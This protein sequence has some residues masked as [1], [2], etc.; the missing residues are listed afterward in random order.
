VIETLEAR[1]RESGC[2]IRLGE[3]VVSLSVHEKGGK[4]VY[5]IALDGGTAMEADAVVVAL[6]AAE[7]AGLLEPFAEVS[8]M[9]NIRYLSVANVVFGYDAAGFDHPLDGTGFLV[10]Q[11]EKRL[12]TASTWTSAKWPHSAPPDKRLIRCYVGRDGEEENVELSD[13]EMT[14]GVYRDLQELMGLTAKPAFVEITRLRHSMPQYP[15]GHRQMV[16]KFLAEVQDR[17]PGVVPAGQPFGGVGLPDCVAQ[18]RK[19]AE[20]IV[21][22]LGE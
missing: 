5:R 15:V 10:P 1:L 11:G 18:G 6:P 9:R 4:P 22:W 12:I 2:D 14:A 13:E 20:T 17:L 21:R 19:A 16:D 3:K 7:I 8:A